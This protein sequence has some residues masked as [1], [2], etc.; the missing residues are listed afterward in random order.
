MRQPARTSLPN[1]PPSDHAAPDV[2]GEHGGVVFQRERL[3][4]I[5][6]ELLPLIDIDYQENGIADDRIPF[7]LNL[8]KYLDYDLLG[9]LQIVTAREAGA[10]VGYMMV[11][12]HPHIDHDGCGWAIINWY[13]IYP[14][15]RGEGVG[16]ALAEVTIGFLRTAG[17]R[18]VEASE[19]IAHKHGLFERLG[20]APTDTIFR[21]VLED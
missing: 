8:E 19:K 14:E 20:F 4:P 9:I 18:V 12:Q 6:R 5:L 1:S 3:A 13:W 10:L 11:F 7:K 2:L 17:V 21:K 15:Y 16:R